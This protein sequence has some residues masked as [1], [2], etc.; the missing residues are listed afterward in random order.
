MSVR[1]YKNWLGPQID[2]FLFTLCTK[3]YIFS[4]PHRDAQRLR[5]QRPHGEKNINMEMGKYSKYIFGKFACAIETC[6]FYVR[7]E[8]YIYIY[9][10]NDLLT[11]LDLYEYKVI[12]QLWRPPHLE[13]PKTLQHILERGNT[14]G[15]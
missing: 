10:Y 6:I 3:K 9:F 4:P 2:R 1:H 13:H 7:G 5:E 12:N 8:A 14:K 15:R 11:Y